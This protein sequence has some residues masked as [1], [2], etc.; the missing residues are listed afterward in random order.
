MF[1]SQPSLLGNIHCNP[2]LGGQFG[3]LPSSDLE[4]EQDNN[5]PLLTYFAAVPK[6]QTDLELRPAWQSSKIQS[7]SA[8]TRKSVSSQT[9][10]KTVTSFCERRTLNKISLKTHGRNRLTL[11]HAFITNPEALSSHWHLLTTVHDQ[12]ISRSTEK[13]IEASWMKQKAQVCCVVVRIKVQTLSWAG[14]DMEDSFSQTCKDCSVNAFPIFRYEGR[15]Q[16]VRVVLSDCK[17]RRS[18]ICDAG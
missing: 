15:Y 16:R 10:N 14:L 2:H 4:D 17:D 12:R 9:S 8:L 11:G 3:R 6:S 13:P 5:R 18:G 1:H 7:S